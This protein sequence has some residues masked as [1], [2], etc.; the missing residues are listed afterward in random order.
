MS[1]K[2]QSG[3]DYLLLIGGAILVAVVVISVLIGL[4]FP[5]GF[6][7]SYEHNA[8]FVCESHQMQLFDFKHEN[9]KLLEVKCFDEKKV[10]MAIFEKKRS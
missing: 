4:A 2:G 8:E 10:G 7:Q 5:L 6:K 1:E 3:L 9:D